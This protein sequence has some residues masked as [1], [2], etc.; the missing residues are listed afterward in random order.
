MFETDCLNLIKKYF[1]K[2]IMERRLG[3]ILED[4]PK[5]FYNFILTSNEAKEIREEEDF[6]IINSIVE[7]YLFL[8]ELKKGF[9]KFIKKQS[10]LREHILLFLSD[11]NYFFREKEEFEFSFQ[12]IIRGVS[13]S[14]SKFSNSNNK[15]IIIK[16]YTLN[17]LFEKKTH[18]I[19]SKFFM[20]S[21]EED[22]KL[23]NERSEVFFN[24]ETFRK[25]VFSFLE[26]EFRKD[27][28]Y[29]IF[30]VK[31]LASREEIKKPNKKLTFS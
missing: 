19:P 17:I 29:G 4:K 20:F 2:I 15:F 26:I 23:K 11:E 28:F 14:I 10:K 12:K 24:L 6:Y 22:E 9:I 8:L 3:S 27:N 13:S 18:T 21:R 16:F 7:N 25:R 31:I 30:C 5:E 1:L